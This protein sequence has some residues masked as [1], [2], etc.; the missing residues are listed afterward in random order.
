[1]MPI[2]YSDVTL[3]DLLIQYTYDPLIYFP[4]SKSSNHMVQKHENFIP[5]WKGNVKTTLAT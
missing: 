3:H 4:G 5:P 1:M 2:E